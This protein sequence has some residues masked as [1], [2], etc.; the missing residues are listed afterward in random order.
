M[1]RDVNDN[2]KSNMS[3]K[4]MMPA[5]DSAAN[6]PMKKKSNGKYFPSNVFPFVD[7]NPIKF[8]LQ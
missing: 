4:T 8:S 6:V 3:E 2:R 1:L 5:S 7:E